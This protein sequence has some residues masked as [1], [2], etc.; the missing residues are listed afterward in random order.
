MKSYGV[1]IQTK[2]LPRY[3]HMILFVLYSR[4]QPYGHLGKTV[5]LLLRPFFT[6]RQNGH[7]FFY[8]KKKPR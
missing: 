2:P 5:T 6:A 8:K 1:T 4:T 7:T 3:L